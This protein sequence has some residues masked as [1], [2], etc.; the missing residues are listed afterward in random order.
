MAAGQRQRRLRPGAGPR[1]HRG[2]VLGAAALALAIA[3]ACVQDDGTRW[4]PKDIIEVSQQEERALGLEFDRW[5]REHLEIIEDPV[6]MG[7]IHDLGQSIVRTIEPQPFV[8]RFRV[9]RDDRLNAF[10]VPGGYIYFHSA[11]ILRAGSLQ[12]VAGVMGHEIAHVKARH[13]KRGVEAQTIPAALMQLAAVG[14]SA[15]TGH[16]APMIVGMG[17]NVAFQLRYSREFEME[18]DRFGSVFMTRAGYDVGGMAHFFERIVAEDTLRP[19]GVEVPPYLFTHPAVEERIDSVRALADE[20]QPVATP[21][22]DMERAFAEAQARLALLEATDRTLWRGP[23]LPADKA[24]SDPALERARTAAEQGDTD[25]ALAVLRG[26]ERA[27]PS[28][29]RLPL[30]LGELLEEEG[31]IEEAAEAYRRAVRL[32]PT[33]GLVLYKLGRT[34]ARLGDRHRAAYYLEQATLHLGAGSALRRSAERGIERLEF[35][36]VREAGLAAELRSGE[37][38]PARRRFA[39]G[40]AVVWWGRIG[41]RY[42]D[43]REQMR[44]RWAGPGGEVRHETPVRSEGPSYAVAEIPSAP[45]PR[46]AGTWTVETLLQDDVV[47]RRTFEVTPAGDA[48]A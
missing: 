11:T 40:E 30:H 37:P 42:L 33:T 34:Y 35:P 5:A 20:L 1:R 27:A 3:A 17:L 31:R 29:P 10:A 23:L 13:Y 26:A 12:E 48:G 47:D 4:S 19:P 9:I 18:A 14:A 44:V 32:D 8:Y 28:D 43:L 16:P 39:P 21:P 41:P 45:R 38:G 7:F 2:G 6:V 25:T 15:A 36:V 24:R 46:T 22:P